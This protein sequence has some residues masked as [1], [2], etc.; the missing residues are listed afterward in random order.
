LLLLFVVVVQERKRH[1]ESNMQVFL[2]DIYAMQSKFPEAARMY[3]SAGV[4]SRALNMYTDLC[5][6]EMAKVRVT[7]PS[8]PWTMY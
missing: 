8:G 7:T 1:G 2:G 6:F 4:P 3:K 5:M